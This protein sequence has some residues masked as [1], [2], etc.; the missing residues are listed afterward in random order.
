VSSSRHAHWGERAKKKPS[1]TVD[2]ADRV[3]VDAAPTAVWARLEDVDAVAQCLPGLVPGSLEPA[4]ENR[5]TALLEH[6]AMGFTAH[7][8]LLATIELSSPEQRMHVVLEGRDPKLGLTMDGWATVVLGGAVAGDDGHV[9]ALQYTGHVH[10][11]GSLAGVGGPIIR[12][13][14]TDALDRFVQGVSGRE[15][16]ARLGPFARFWRRIRQWL[17]S[18]P[19]GAARDD[20]DRGLR[21]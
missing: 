9:S 5:Y 15:P 6:S 1:T 19:G 4:G 10:V 8:D 21:T 17:G 14:V 16:E 2:V 18:G 7:W 12:G 20:G 3:E 11:E 13:I